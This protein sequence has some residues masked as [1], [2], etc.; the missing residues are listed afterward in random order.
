MG[1]NQTAC[2]VTS[3][4]G[5]LLT[6]HPL[7]LL[8]FYR[9]YLGKNKGFPDGSVVKSPPQSRRSG[10]HLWSGKIPHAA[11]QLSPC[12]TTTRPVLQSPGTATA[13]PVCHRYRSP[14]VP[15]LVLHRRRSL[16]TVT[17]EQP[18]LA[19]TREKPV[20]LRRPSRAKTK[21]VNKI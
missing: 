13:E 20:Q 19:A 9:I 6:K 4:P 18:P 16:C 1:R 11:E 21:C 5:S 12:P 15:E 2:G 3:L 10:S 8:N 17:R 14:R 7:Y